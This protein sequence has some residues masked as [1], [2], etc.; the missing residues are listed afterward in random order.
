[1]S[2]KAIYER[3]LADPKP[4]ALSRDVSLNYITTTTTFHGADAV[5]KHLSSQ[6]KIVKKKS[7]KTLSAI[8]ASDAL[9]LDVETTLEFVSGGGA[10]LPSLDD[11]FLADRVVTFPMVH[12]VRFDSQNQIQQI[13]LY[14]DQGSLL[15]QVD[16]IGSRG[17]NW[18]IRDAQEQTRLITSSSAGHGTVTPP[19]QSSTQEP[20]SKKPLKDPHASLSLFSSNGAED[21]QP[22]VIAPRAAASK[23]PPQRDY[24]EL[25]VGDPDDDTTPTKNSSSRKDGVVAPKGASKTFGPNRLFDDDETVAA[26]EKPR[27]AIP[28]KAGAGKNFQPIRLFEEGDADQGNQKP[29]PRYR[30]H[31]NKF[32]HFE[33]GENN[34]GSREIKSIPSRPKSR[35][36]SQWDFEDFTTPEKPKGKIRGQDVRHFGWSDNEEDVQETPPA[37]PR[38]VHPRR[39]A[40]THFKF[41]DDGSQPAETGP[42]RLIGSAHN[43]GLR[44]Y[45]N[46]LYDEEGNPTPNETEGTAPLSVHPNGAHRK[47]DFDSHWSISDASPPDEKPKVENRPISSDRI[48]A[49]K[50]MD[51]SWDTYDESP[52]KEVP[53]AQTKRTSRIT[54]RSWT[55]GD[56]DV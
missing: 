4:D 24:T 37:R 43:R 40:E 35:H 3:F 51:A 31:P 18:P 8:E 52:Q 15:K 17:R 30:P 25:F 11:N 50:M 21:D 9:V 36:L 26:E 56:E 22:A 54:Q 19:A 2:L 47:K 5:L 34:D 12:I 20:A 10:Y 48:K 27:G 16:V 49:V 39:D 33:L 42:K 1:M 14:W 32:D 41:E 46:N 38:V 55:F 44:L 13:R 45:E 29:E 28:P 53:P 23:K 6:Q 7:D